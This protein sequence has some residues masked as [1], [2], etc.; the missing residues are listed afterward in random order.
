MTQACP[1]LKQEMPTGPPIFSE[2]PSMNISMDSLQNMP[3]SAMVLELWQYSLIR[4][5]GS[6]RT[7]SYVRSK[8]TGME[9]GSCMEGI[10]IL[11]KS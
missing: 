3:Q 5:A 6:R 2:Q 1:Y 4:R 11:A 9:G 10:V 8:V 7:M